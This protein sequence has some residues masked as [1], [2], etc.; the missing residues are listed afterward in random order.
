MAA[1]PGTVVHVS[2]TTTILLVLLASVAVSLL[3]A[4]LLVRRAR[5]RAAAAVAT[6]GPPLRT[7]AATAL[8]STGD[9]VTAVR[10]TGTL[11]VTADEV[12]FA[13]WMPAQLLRI[14]RTDIV[15]TDTTRTHAGRTMKTDVLRITWTA[16]GDEAAVAFFVRELDAW[17]SDL[18]GRRSAED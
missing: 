8:G 10:G 4:L 5:G 13:Q 3:V 14:P 16:D 6:L 1:H 15:R 2:A 18:G 7:T 11:V 12:A 17:L 9:Q